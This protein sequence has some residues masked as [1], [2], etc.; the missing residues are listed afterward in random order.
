ME[1]NNVIRLSAVT[2]VPEGGK[3]ASN[4]IA[5]V[6]QFR[7]SGQKPLIAIGDLIRELRESIPP[8][9][10]AQITE[11]ISGLLEILTAADQASTIAEVRLNVAG[12][13][14]RNAEM[15][16]KEA[17]AQLVAAKKSRLEA[18][19]M[20]AELTAVATK[21]PVT[22]PGRRARVAGQKLSPP[23]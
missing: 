5:E 13:M 20:R 23:K 7:A 22:K 9:L 1:S 12:E 11:V 4:Q 21:R 6:I 2:R 17:S 16:L 19:R 18:E 10:E 8:G 3:E 14:L 15:I